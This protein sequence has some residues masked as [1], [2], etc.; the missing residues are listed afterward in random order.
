M[1]V[2][3]MGT[4]EIAK[5]SLKALL[6]A[7]FDVI[8]VFT[9]PDKPKNRGMKMEIPPVKELA[10]EHNI[11]VFQ[12]VSL[13]DGETESIL[14]ELAPDIIAVVAYGKLIPEYIISIPP[15]GCINI[16]ASLLP[17]YR[18][19]APIQWSVLNGDKVTGMTSM[20]IK[21]ELDAGD[22][23]YKSELEIGD[24]ET[25][26]EL[27]ARMSPVGGELLVK[28]LR[29]IEA[30]VAPREVQ[31]EAEFTHAPM[32]SREMS[33]INWEKSPKEIVKH[34]CGMNPWPSA[35]TTINEL[36]IKVHMA[37]F[38]ENRTNKAAGEIVSAGKEGIEIA[39]LNGETVML[40]EV[41]KSGGKKMSAADFLRGNP[42]N[43]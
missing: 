4:P 37:N 38:T 23:I 42:I 6:D 35:T 13:K 41:Q 9:Q 32:L 24:Y 7:N 22:M 10:L 43:V 28:T 21:K 39:C 11:P 1:K 19:S 25:S 5:A 2:V 15:K 36:N 18:G 26:G 16:H 27:F 29:D 17:K 30:G 34:I 14:N 31:N 12:P 8:A 3:F 20:Y 40:T 33:P